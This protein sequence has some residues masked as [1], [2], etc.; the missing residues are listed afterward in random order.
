MYIFI[1]TYTWI[2]HIAIAKYHTL[3]WLSH[4]VSFYCSL[5]ISK[6]SK[7][8][9]I[10]DPR[11]NYLGLNPPRLGHFTPSW[12]CWKI[13]W[14]TCCIRGWLVVM[15]WASWATA[16]A[17]EFLFLSLKLRD[18]C[19]EMALSLLTFYTLYITYIPGSSFACIFSAFS[20]IIAYYN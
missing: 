14:G 5:H 4:G 10:S 20:E 1:Y 6:S 3:C 12:C 16:M 8:K 19:T 18:S 15:V 13:C 17:T 9:I 11:S 2:H 7:R